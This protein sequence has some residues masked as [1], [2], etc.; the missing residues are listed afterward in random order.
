MPHQSDKSTINTARW[1]R[2]RRAL[3]LRATFRCECCNCFTGMAGQGDHIVSRANCAAQ[4]IDPFDMRNLQWLCAS[5]HAKR[6]NAERF[7]NHKPK[8]KQRRRTP[9][10]GRDAYLTAIQAAQ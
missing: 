2:V 7:K 3:A 4:G 6:T 10:K 8:P 5:C 9:V 1:Q